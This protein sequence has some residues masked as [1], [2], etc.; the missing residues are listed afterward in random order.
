[1][2]LGNALVA[3][4][5]PRGYGM[6]PQAIYHRP[7]LPPPHYYVA[8]YRWLRDVWGAD[9]IV[10]VGKHGSVE[11]LPGKGVGLSGECFPE[12]I[13][14]DLPLF[15][16]FIKSDPGEGMQAKRRARAVVVDHLI[17]A[18]TTADAY[19]ELEQLT[20]LVDEYYQVEMLDPSKLPLLQQQIW[21]LVRRANLDEDLKQVFKQDHGDHK[22]EWDEGTTAE[23]TP[24]WLANLQGREFAHVVEDLDAYPCEL[25][26]PAPRSATGSTPSA[27]R[28]RESNSSI[29]SS[30]SPDCRTSRRR[31]SGPHSPGRSASTSTRC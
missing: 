11:W 19:G 13:L 3:L 18:M 17:P 29:S 15:Y 30:R 27:A 28:R 26:W 31:A 2:P 7:D 25:A 22:H 23:G 5:P 16:P 12:T 6:D 24:L 4:Q 21:D 20:Q 1:M 9:A 8:L 10:H 14:G